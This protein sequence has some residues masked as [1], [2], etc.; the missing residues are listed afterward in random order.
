MLLTEYH[1]LC[2]SLGEQIFEQRPD[3][4]D[5][6]TLARVMTFVALIASRGEIVTLWSRNVAITPNVELT[7]ARHAGSE[8]QTPP[9]GRPG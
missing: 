2:Q 6:D 7:G 4:K 9:A 3:E 8:D 1:L 5:T